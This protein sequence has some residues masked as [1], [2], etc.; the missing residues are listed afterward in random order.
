MYQD[1]DF[2]G[3]KSSKEYLANNLFWEANSKLIFEVFIESYPLLLRERVKNAVEKILAKMAGSSEK[4]TEKMVIEFFKLVM[5]PDQ[6]L[7]AMDI[8]E[9]FKLKTKLMKGN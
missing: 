4:V 8:V 7:G 9:T 6:F 3:S 5:P 2:I 1:K